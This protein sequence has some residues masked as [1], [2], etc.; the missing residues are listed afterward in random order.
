M[1]L[2]FA[3]GLGALQD[4]IGVACKSLEEKEGKMRSWEKYRR[5]ENRDEGGAKREREGGESGRREREERE[6]G[7][8]ERERAEGGEWNRRKEKKKKKKQKRNKRRPLPTNAATF[9]ESN[10]A[11]PRKSSSSEKT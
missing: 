8:R 4:W 6:G 11:F 3:F 1:D 9:C 5:K 2:V 7:E 10:S